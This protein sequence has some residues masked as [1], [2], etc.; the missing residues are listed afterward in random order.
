MTTRFI[1]LRIAVLLVAA[2]GLVDD[3]GGAP[4]S[5]DNRPGATLL[6]PYFEVDL[7]DPDGRDTL[8]SVNNADHAPTLAHVVLWTDRG[9]PTLGFDVYLAPHGGR[10][11]SLRHILVEGRLP[12]TGG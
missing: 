2:G 12:A 10:S 11:F 5:S 3:A 4:C 1:W 7:D 6:I 8:F 9:L